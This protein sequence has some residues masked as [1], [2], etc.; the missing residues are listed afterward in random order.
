MHGA[1]VRESLC[2]GGLCPFP[3]EVV[4]A[5]GVVVVV[6]AKFYYRWHN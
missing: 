2:P 4:A 6:E 3:V 5:V 1:S